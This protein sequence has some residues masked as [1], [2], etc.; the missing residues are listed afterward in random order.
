MSNEPEGEHDETL[1]R[2]KR[3][4][5]L[6][7]CCMSIFIVGMDV[8]IVNVALPSIR[9]SLHAS[10][11][12]LQWTIDAYTL[13]LASFLMLAG[14]MGDR[15]GRRHVFQVGLA[16]FSTGSLLC[17]VAP[18]LGLLIAA[19]MVQALGGTM[20]NPIAMSIIRNTFEDPRERAAAIGVWGGVVGLSMALGP[21]VGG[22]LVVGAGWRWIFLVNVPVGIAAIVLTALHVPD[23]RAEHV[24]RIDPIGQVL[25]IVIL[26]TVVFAIIQGP[27]AGWFSAEILGL[28]AVS[29][30]SL[31][32]FVY[33]ELHREEPLLEIRFFRS[34]P[35]S[36]ASLIAVCAFSALGGFLF[37]NTLYLQEARG[38]SA[39]HA[40]LYTLPMAAMTVIFGPISGRLIGRVG[41]RPSLMVAGVAM[42]AGM[43]LLT[44][45]QP[46]TSVTRLFI[47]YILFG[48]GFG[49][50]N[51]P[52]TNAAVSGMPPAQAGV[53]AAIASSSRQLGSTL[54]VAIV[55]AAVGAS[56]SFGAGL[57]PRFAAATHPG[58]WIIAGFTAAV[59]PLGWL[60]T[61]RRAR[62]GA[63]RVARDRGTGSLGAIAARSGTSP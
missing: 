43:L 39:F 38:L 18:N 46:H 9:H 15:L 1:S 21:V 14:S 24:R 22:A 12:G 51:P 17:A 40:G 11:S 42:T 35:F 61:T 52:I 62:E 3:M 32:T 23:S 2:R 6:A 29:A 19:R 50:V 13:V 27:S 44:G 34:R 7:S 8:T 37:I 25:V 33:H 16:L 54:G 36:N 4:L 59:L 20:L 60:A 28:F 57:D 48:A 53:A 56:A 45:I 63:D 55:G 41:A 10:V 47:A 26:A 30:A 49:L 5:V 58:W 31:A